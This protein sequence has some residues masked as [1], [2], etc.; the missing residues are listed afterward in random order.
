[1]APRLASRKRPRDEGDRPRHE[2]TKGAIGCGA[3]HFRIWK[4]AVE[5]G[6]AALVFEDD[7]V[8]RNDFEAH[9]APLI[10]SLENWDFLALGYNTDSILDLEIARGMNSALVFA[11]KYPTPGERGRVSE[12]EGA[13]RRVPAQLLLRHFG[14]YG[15]PRGRQEAPPLL[16]SDG[17]P[18][19]H[20]PGAEA[21]VSG[22]RPRL[23]A[24]R[25]L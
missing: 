8:I 4:Q 22:L 24:D 11:P 1:M 12:V 2:L 16:L 19:D 10:A 17:Q 6:E 13:G 9:L 5:T 21:L 20:H 3:S 15:V 23:H 7:A 14:L 18:A 25:R